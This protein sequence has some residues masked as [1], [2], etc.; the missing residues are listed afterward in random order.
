[1]VGAMNEVDPESKVLYAAMRDEFIG[2]VRALSDEERETIVPNCPAW[3]VRDVVAHVTGVNVDVVSGNVAALGADE[4]TQ[5]Q[6]ESRAAMSLAE[7]CNEWEGMAARTDV[8][9]SDDPFW[10]VRIGADLVSHIHDVLEALSRSDD[11]LPVS[12][13]D[14]VGIRSALSRYGPFFCERAGSASLPLVSVTV[15][16]DE[17]G[18]QAWHSGDGVAAAE[19]S[20]SAFDL[21]RAFT[22]RRS[23]EQVLAMEWTGDPEPYLA[24]I[25]PYGA[26]KSDR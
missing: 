1:M 25:N 8:F 26:L 20:G 6:V 22:G 5:G 9:I 17:V 10:G 13:R 12:S 23:L 21:L 24:M 11:E 4:W 19:L 16:P 14:G 2:F 18:G 15:V 3:T 7:L